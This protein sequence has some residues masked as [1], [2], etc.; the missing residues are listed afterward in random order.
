MSEIIGFPTTG[1][2]AK[3]K[4]KALQN[5]NT[6][7]FMDSYVQRTGVAE[8]DEDNDLGPSEGEDISMHGDGTIEGGG[9]DEEDPED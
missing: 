7:T 4:P 6:G 9:D 1:P 8:E 2:T 5:S 3:R